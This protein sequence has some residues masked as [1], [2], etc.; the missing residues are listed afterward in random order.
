M[1]WYSKAAWGSGFVRQ[2]ARFSEEG[3]YSYVMVPRST[4]SRHL[5]CLSSMCLTL[6][7]CMSVCNNNVKAD[8]LSHLMTVGEEEI[9]PMYFM[10]FRSH[11][12]SRQ[13]ALA[14]MYSA[15]HVLHAIVGWKRDCQ[16]IAPPKRVNTMPFVLQVSLLSPMKSELAQPAR[17]LE[18]LFPISNW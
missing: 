16:Q 18:L 5:W 3:Q 12:A 4:S 2:S 15:S 7:E 8:L 17:P 13:A 14:A 6:D 11:I 9:L 1:R 10:T